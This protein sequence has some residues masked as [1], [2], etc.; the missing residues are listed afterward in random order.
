VAATG[1]GPAATS[2]SATCTPATSS[3]TANSATAIRSAYNSARPTC[4]GAYA[5]PMAATAATA[6]GATLLTGRAAGI[7]HLA[8]GAGR[9]SR[10][11]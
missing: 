11:T 9:T 8:V 10:P 3:C 5:C 7:T 2:N 4:S 1:A 6:R